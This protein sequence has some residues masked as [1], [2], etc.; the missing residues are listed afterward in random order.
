MV[1]SGDITGLHVAKSDY[2]SCNV[3]SSSQSFDYTLIRLCC[4]L[5]ASFMSL[6]LQ[7]KF[8]S[9]APFIVLFDLP[10]HRTQINHTCISKY[11]CTEILKLFCTYDAILSSVRK[12]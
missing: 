10:A 3:R 2:A 12:L 7:F 4:L 9:F 8:Y 11:A 1:R 6:T 5:N